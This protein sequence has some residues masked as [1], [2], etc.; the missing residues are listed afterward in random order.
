M[1]SPPAKRKRTE[2]T[3]ITRSE[4]WYKDGSVVLQAENTQF[5][6][7]LPQPPNQPTVDGCSIVE[8]QDSAEDVEYLL[9]A[10][11]DPQFLGQPALTLAAVGALIRLGRK[12]D[13]QTIF[14][15][16][17]ARITSEN[18]TTLEAYDALIGDDGIYKPTRIADCGGFRFE[19]LTLVRENNILSALPVAYYRASHH[20]LKTL[21]DVSQKGTPLFLAPLDLG[22]CLIGRERLMC[23]QFQPNYSLGFLL[24]A[25]HPGCRSPAQCDGS[26]KSVFVSWTDMHVAE[27]FSFSDHH[28]TWPPCAT[29]CKHALEANT[30]GRKKS[31]EE[32]PAIFDLPSW[33]QLKND[34]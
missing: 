13:F 30:A 14:E 10:V 6:V 21:L 12:Y 28:S 22:R 15:S 29:C 11:Y 33:D 32:L 1:S 5:R 4:I 31:W 25:Q 9:K 7:A 18:P 8:L 26:R 16:A 34:V 20:R 2:T 24:E 23:K 19:L 17:M 27:P 3:S